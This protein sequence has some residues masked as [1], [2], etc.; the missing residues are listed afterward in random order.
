[1]SR[2]TRR[3]WL[4]VVGLPVGL[5]L[6]VLPF[7]VV[8]W[9]PV[10]YVEGLT[11]DMRVAATCRPDQGGEAVGLVVKDDASD[12]QVDL[13]YWP[14]ALYDRA[15]QNLQQVGADVVA[16]DILLEER[17]GHG[18]ESRAMDEALAE[19]LAGGPETVL[20]SRLYVEQD[21]DVGSIARYRTP[22]VRFSRASTAEG[23]INLNAGSGVVRH[24]PL[25]QPEPARDGAWVP[26]LALATY[27]VRL[28]ADAWVAVG[29]D[30]RAAFLSEAE[31]AVGAWAQTAR[32]KVGDGATANGFDA[33]VRGDR[34]A[35]TA[36]AE[37]L[38]RAGRRLAGDGGPVFTDAV[39][40]RI[41]RE[42]TVRFLLR[43]VA[44]QVALPER[45]PGDRAFD[46]GALAASDELLQVLADGLGTSL[47]LRPVAADVQGP[48]LTVTFDGYGA[49]QTRSLVEMAN[50]T[51]LF[52]EGRSPIVDRGAARNERLH[53]EALRPVG[54]ARLRGRVVRVDGHPV[55]GCRVVF[56]AAGRRWG[57]T[58]ADT[59]GRF[60]VEGLCS[61]PG[62][63][64]LVAGDVTYVGMAVPGEGEGRYVLPSGQGRLVVE[65]LTPGGQVIVVGRALLPRWNVPAGAAV[66]VPLCGAPLLLEVTAKEGDRVV[67]ETFV[68]FPEDVAGLTHSRG[69]R[70]SSRLTVEAM[71]AVDD[72]AAVSLVPRVAGTSAALPC[73]VTVA[74]MGGQWTLRRTVRVDEAGTASFDDLPPGRY[75][76]WRSPGTAPERGF[77]QV[78]GDGV[79]ALAARDVPDGILSPERQT[80]VELRCRVPGV[81]RAAFVSA[82]D[83]DVLP[84]HERSAGVFGLT[85]GAAEGSGFVVVEGADGAHAVAEPGTAWP[86]TWLVGTK[87][88][89]DQDFYATPVGELSGVELH[90]AAFLTLIH[91][92]PV[93]EPSLAVWVLCL[94]VPYGVVAMGLCTLSLGRSVVLWLSVT[95]GYLVVAWWAMAHQWGLPVAAPMLFLVACPG[96]FLSFRV[97]EERREA[98]RRKAIFQKFIDP[99][100]VEQLLQ[101][102]E[103][104][105]HGE[106]RTLTVMFSDIRGFTTLSEIHEPHDVTG[107]LNEYFNRML[108]VLHKYQGTLDKFIG[109]AIMAFFGA[110]VAQPD[111]A[112]RAVAVAVEMLHETRKLAA[113]RERRSAAGDD[114]ARPPFKIGFGIATGPCQVGLVGSDEVFNYSVIGDTVNLASR[115]EGLN[116]DFR[117][118]ILVDETTWRVVE[119][120]VEGRFVDHV[121]VKGR[122]EPAAVYRI[123]DFKGGR[124]DA[125]LL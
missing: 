116:K 2:G 27:L 61:G 90:A 13:P 81:R 55:A 58:T 107:M 45:W 96:V 125:F 14:R 98:E 31:A 95:A 71:H 36:L 33:A 25:Y 63:L 124:P 41:R 93:R 43:K 11:Y 84:L 69:A 59:N 12:E 100:V 75:E 73:T 50:Q 122:H 104:A 112:R 37:V 8:G 87:V 49:L 111:H 108:P 6:L 5:L 10:A 40:E 23:F 94:L 4:R 121:A 78:V 70:S 26:S 82:V 77:E 7:V 99:T 52:G 67:A 109:D 22:L 102:E 46:G 113:E 97:Y 105:L 65:G 68:E 47:A 44:R 85:T 115:L 74:P 118:E 32:E 18:A 42:L 123:I 101:L 20:A 38:A 62:H 83:G 24:V 39:V 34:A 15:L 19:T 21:P 54:S 72:G 86:S 119:D 48:W 92:S 103:V 110:P 16:L 89:A 35:A 17:G 106:R 9:Q 88:R 29:D 51:K 120:F 66:T 60:V 114:R 76:L 53:C 117:S 56:A 91:G 64:W 79:V 30:G 80:T 1:L 3:L 57:G 28:M